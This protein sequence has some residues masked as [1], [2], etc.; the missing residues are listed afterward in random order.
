MQTRWF[1]YPPKT[2]DERI[3]CR[4]YTQ[5]RA[6]AKCFKSTL[7]LLLC[8]TEKLPFGSFL[9]AQNNLSFHVLDGSPGCLHQAT[10][11][12]HFLFH[13]PEPSTVLMLWETAEE[14]WR[15]TLIIAVKRCGRF[16]ITGKSVLYFK[17][18]GGRLWIS[19]ESILAQSYC[20]YNYGG[21]KLLIARWRPVVK[22]WSPVQNFWSHWRPGKCNFGPWLRD[23]VWVECLAQ[24]HNTVSPVRAWILTAWSKDGPTNHEA[25]MPP[26]Y[27]TKHFLN[28][29][30]HLKKYK[31]TVIPTLLNPIEVNRLIFC[32]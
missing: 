22:F 5:F 7:Y 30:T 6:T 32:S 16:I 12:Q 10:T 21:L 4:P 27:M 19:F 17:S 28:Y 3:E 8:P 23:F 14:T 11:V 15:L 29:L 24:K 18:K 9:C 25:N 20:L 31:T 13:S 26:T 2:Q 1:I